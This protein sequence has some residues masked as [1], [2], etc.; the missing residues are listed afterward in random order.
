MNIVYAFI[1]PL[2][3]YSIDTVNQ[4]RLFFDGPLYF[5]VSDLSSA[6]VPVLQDRYNVTIVPYESV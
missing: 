1:G 6:Y 2:P 5:I 4:T 3:S